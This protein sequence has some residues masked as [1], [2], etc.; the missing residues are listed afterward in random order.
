M[1]LT[2]LR[3]KSLIHPPKW[4]PENTHYLV[5]MGSEAYGCSSGQ[6]DQDI[7]GWCIP[8]KE[9]VFP[10]L[11]GEIQGFGRQKSKFDVWQEHHVDDPESK[12]RYDFSV[13]SAVK[14]V[15]LC[16]ENNPN[17]VDAL[18]VPTRCV[19]HCTKIGNIL[20][21][22]R[23]IFLHKGCWHKY[24][25][26]AYSQLHKMAIKTP[27]EGSK[28]HA[29]VLEHGYDVKFAYH[30]VR[31]ILE[32]EQIMVEQDLDLERNREILK[33]IRR[34]DWTEERIREFFTEKEKSLEAVYHN[35][36]LRYKPNED[37]IKTV[38]LQVLEEHYGSL[39]GA[40]T[41]PNAEKRC[42][43][44]IKSILERYNV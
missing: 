8:P 19:M 43:Q 32:V 36:D 18:F 2:R 17:M 9:S 29:S 20:R 4:L 21:D 44:E 40:I 35:S 31:L 33:S 38:L 37:E 15:H 25:G 26:Y 7:Y 30:V 12:K 11:A 42:L 24:K 22:N 34:G 13:Y 41:I 39:D 1:L 10:H 16:M 3:E 6:S 5:R 23:K 14:F 28:R 27:Q